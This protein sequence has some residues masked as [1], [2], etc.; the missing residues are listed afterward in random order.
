MFMV[1]YVLSQSCKTYGDC[2]PGPNCE[3]R[4]DPITKK[5]PCYDCCDGGFIPWEWRNDDI[6]DCRNGSDMWTKKSMKSRRGLQ[7]IER[8]QDCSLDNQCCSGACK[9]GKCWDERCG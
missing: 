3:N 8:K 1:G 4:V 2:D 9:D 5:P 6:K 7:C